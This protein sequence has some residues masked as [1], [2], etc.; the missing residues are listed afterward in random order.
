[1]ASG[2]GNDALRTE[3]EQLVTEHSLALYFKDRLAEHA[4]RLRAPLHD[5]TCWYIGT[6]L[7]RFMRSDRLFSYQDGTLALR[8]LALLYGDALEA[9]SERQR[10]LLLRQLGDLALFLGALF[11]DRYLKRGIRQEYFVGMGGGAYDYLA[12][13]AQGNR[14]VYAQLAETFTAL[15]DLV[16]D[17]CRRDAAKT[18]SD[19]LALYERWVRTGDDRLAR[20]LRRLGIVVPDAFDTH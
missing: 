3:S 7:E 11:P 5:D 12:G 18:E 10:C 4:T 9:P 15:L 13:N 16:A 17:A 1:M 20:Q 19:V 8:P 2:D 14:H 6:L